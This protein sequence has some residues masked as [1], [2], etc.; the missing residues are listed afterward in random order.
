MLRVWT[1]DPALDEFQSPG[2]GFNASQDFP[3]TTQLTFIYFIAA[4]IIGYTGFV[5]EI[6]LV[7]MLKQLG[8]KPEAAISSTDIDHRNYL[9]NKLF[10]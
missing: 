7:H 1:P 6:Q 4:R 5:V 3:I 2:L 10:M 9:Q 8:V